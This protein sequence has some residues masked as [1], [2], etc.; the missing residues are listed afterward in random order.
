[1]RAVVQEAGLDDPHTEA[2]VEGEVL[3]HIRGRLALMPSPRVFQVLNLLTFNRTK[4]ASVRPSREEM[5]DRALEL[6]DAM[7]EAMLGLDAPQVE[8]EEEETRE[9][10]E[11]VKAEKQRGGTGSEAGRRTAV[12]THFVGWSG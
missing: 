4:G 6:W 7:G 11:G 2:M 10:V 12:L 5:E 1:M 9:E 8:E 3:K